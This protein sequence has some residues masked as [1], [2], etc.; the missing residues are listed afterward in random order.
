MSR[1]SLYSFIY[2]YLLVVAVK[3]NAEEIR[4]VT[5]YLPPY[6]IIKADG[7]LDGFSTDVIKA[8][9]KQTNKTPSF[10]VMSWARAF[11]IA[12]SEQNVMIYSIARTK[13]RSDLFHWIGTLTKEKLYFWGLKSK[14]N[15]EITSEALLKNCSITASKFSNIDE[16][17]SAANFSN[18]YYITLEEQSMKMLYS[19]RIDLLI[20]TELNAKARAKKLGFDFNKLRKIYEVNELNNEL[21]IALSRQSNPELVLQFQQAYKDIVSQGLIEKFKVK[22]G[23]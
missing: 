11:S 21:S 6:Q 2:F 1:F 17:L 23:L 3:S 16:Y 12:S 14:F 18:I 9:F 20:D 7:N 19:K 22:W 10:E 4:V 13:E 8:I 5:E 15:W